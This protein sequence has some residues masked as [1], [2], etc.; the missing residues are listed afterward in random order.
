MKYTVHPTQI[1]FLVVLF[2]LFHGLVFLPVLLSII[3]PPP[4][5]SAEAGEGLHHSNAT[6]VTAALM[7]TDTCQLEKP[8]QIEMKNGSTT[9]S[10]LQKS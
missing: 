4:Y 10:D 3:G 6:A 5:P 7:R 8:E 2:G 1:F 9:S